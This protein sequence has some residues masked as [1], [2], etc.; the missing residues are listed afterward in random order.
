[1][2]FTSW[3]TLTST[4]VTVKELAVYYSK[5]NSNKGKN[6]LQNG[7][8]SIYLWKHNTKLT[9]HTPTV[10]NKGGDLAHANSGKQT[11]H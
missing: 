6:K 5:Q 7:A 4:T 9:L 3:N 8:F 10:K 1:M 2:P 11:C